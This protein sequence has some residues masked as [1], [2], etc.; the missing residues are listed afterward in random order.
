MLE[1][2]CILD[3]DVLD[4]LDVLQEACVPLY[5]G[6]HYTKLATTMTPMNMCIVH[7]CSNKF[8]NELFSLLHNFLL[9]MDNILF[10]NMYFVKTL[11]QHIGLKY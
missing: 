4:A 9:P 5:E 3:D 2:L 8:V 11:T 6:A 7:N 10:S 1:D